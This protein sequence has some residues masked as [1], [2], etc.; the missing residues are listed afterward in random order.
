[1]E[2]TRE[3]VAART[4]VGKL[5]PQHPG[6]ALD[7][8]QAIKHPWY[9]CQALSTVAEY[10]SG[11][12]QDRVLVEALAAAQQQDEI[13]R[14][15]TVSSWPLRV[16]VNAGSGLADTY[17]EK[18]VVLADTEP[19]HLRRSHALQAL[20]F[21][22]SGHPELLGRVVPSLV[23]ALIGGRGPRID[24]CIR[25]T[26]ELVQAAKPE[27]TWAVAMHHKPGR[28]RDRLLAAIPQ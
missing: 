10:L 5:A 12:E 21:A 28:Q 23:D 24:R 26:F 13:N 11:R 9:R 18:L 22:V 25:D 6:R 17:L 3:D 4:R 2:I 16:L 19:H 1:M 15:V 27:L 20:A 8:A 7:V 14:I